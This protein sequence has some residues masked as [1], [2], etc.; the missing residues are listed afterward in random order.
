MTDDDSLS[1]YEALLAAFEPRRA[2]LTLSH[3]VRTHRL[4]PAGKVLA[5]ASFAFRVFRGDERR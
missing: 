4:R 1:S 2:L 3:A 5:P